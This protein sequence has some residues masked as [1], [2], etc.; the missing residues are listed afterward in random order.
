MGAGRRGGDGGGGA[1]DRGRGGGGRDGLARA[2]G[3]ARELM[4]C[5]GRLEAEL[6][7]VEVCE[8][9]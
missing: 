2:L 3:A 4:C 9:S 5:Y 6:R 8:G 7:I 1:G